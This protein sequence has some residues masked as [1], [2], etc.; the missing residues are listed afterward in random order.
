MVELSDVGK[1]EEPSPELNLHLFANLTGT[2]F[3][4]KA[5]PKAASLTLFNT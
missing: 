3:L 5:T 2:L 4:I 1:E